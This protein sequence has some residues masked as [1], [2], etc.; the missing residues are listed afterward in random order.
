MEEIYLDNASTTKVLSS[1][2]EAISRCMLNE[3]GNPS[4]THSFGESASQNLMQARTEISS[5]LSVS[6]SEIVFTSG[7]T[8][9]NNLAVLG[10]AYSKKNKGMHCITS[11]IEHQSVLNSFN[12]LAAEGWEVSYI[13]VDSSGVIN[14]DH[15]AK[16][17]RL[18]TSLVSIMHINNEIGSIQPLKEV[19]NLLLNHPNKPIFHVD[20]VQSFCRYPISPIEWRADT[21]SMSAHKIHASKGTGALYVNKRLKLRPILL[22]GD[23]EHGIRAGTENVPGIVGMAE[24]VRCL[25]QNPGFNSTHMFQLKKMFFDM[26]KSAIPEV[27]L[28]GPSIESGAGHIL[29]VSIP[30]IPAEVM[31]RGL[32]SWYGVHVGTGAACSSKKKYVSYV[33]KAIKLDS[34]LASSVIRVSFSQFNDFEQVERAVAAIKDCSA[35]ISSRKG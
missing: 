33:L 20:A 12:R 8:E 19:S 1:A 26:L 29:S 14:I 17:L 16:A 31:Q 10:A 6:E 18:D 7:G 13:P 22:G 3:Y 25:K 4:S 34:K 27:H 24:A 5:V 21:V 32:S 30:G 2:A 23:Q 28:I 35:R 11:C 15:L 9:A